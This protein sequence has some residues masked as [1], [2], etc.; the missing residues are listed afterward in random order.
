MIKALTLRFAHVSRASEIAAQN[1]ITH[2][3]SSYESL[4]SEDKGEALDEILK[5]ACQVVL[6]K[7]TKCPLSCPTVD[8][9]SIVTP[10][11]LHAPQTIGWP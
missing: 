1:Q 6:V 4:L 7:C 10:V 11:Y 5:F 2:A 8:L 3:F 9:V